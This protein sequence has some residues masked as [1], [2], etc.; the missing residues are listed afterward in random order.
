[1]KFV[2]PKRLHKIFEYLTPP[3]K[4]KKVAAMISGLI[5]GLTIF[6]VHISNAG[7]YLSDEPE[8]CV[9]CHIM[10]PQ[11]LTWEHSAHRNASCN[12]CHVP[13]NNIVRKYYFKAMDGLRHATMF[14]FR[15]EPQ[16]IKIG[17]AGKTVVQENCIRCHK[18]Q[19]SQ[20]AAYAVDG[21][22]YTKGEGALC[23]G[24]HRETPHGRVHSL[25]STTNGI[26][27]ELKP[28]L[29]K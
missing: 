11:Y 28:V 20:V 2:Y 5:V 17:E 21:A 16:V 26:V 4:W 19:V 13:H 8:T 15:L 27:P 25:S 7:S 12:D 24:C 1:M 3:D 29:G 14:T 10:R 22:N 6:I 23:W 9:N 18:D